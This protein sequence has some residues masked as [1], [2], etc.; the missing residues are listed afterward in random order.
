MS[1]RKLASW[2]VVAAALVLLG[3]GATQARATD[4][5]AKAFLNSIYDAYVNHSAGT[6]KGVVPDG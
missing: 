3:M 2:C 6:A 1:L 4:I 5:G